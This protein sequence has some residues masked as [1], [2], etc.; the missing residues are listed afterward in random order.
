MSI[1]TI[2]ENTPANL[3]RLQR[4]SNTKYQ[5]IAPIF[6][7]DGDMMSIFVEEDGDQIRISDNGVSLMRLSYTF[8]IDTDNKSKQLS[9]IVTAQDADNYDGDIVLTVP[10]TEI[11]SGIMRYAQM[12]GQVCNLD[13]LSRETISDLFYDDL[14]RAIA[15]HFSEYK[16]EKN[17]EDAKYGDLPIDYAFLGFGKPVYLFGA[18]DT[19]K[20]YQITV[21]CLS[22]MQRNVSFRSIAVFN[23]IDNIQ[24]FAR[25][26]LMNTAT[27][28]FSDIPGF[29]EKGPDY[30]RK[31][32]GAA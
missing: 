18:K 19:N 11:Y 8:D 1:E 32:L 4:K 7:E 25:N 20:A 27:K 10:R 13:I 5:V 3:F 17:Y 14:E 16:F 12:V 6:H 23:E 24:K 22:L 26:N 30:F 29:L 28:V 9:A 21:C 15:D 2:F 31:E